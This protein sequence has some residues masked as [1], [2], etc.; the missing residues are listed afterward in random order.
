MNVIPSYA[1]LPL[2]PFLLPSSKALGCS[3]ELLPRPSVPSDLDKT[4]YA[5]GVARA[6]SLRIPLSPRLQVQ[7]DTTQHFQR[8]PR[9]VENDRS[10]CVRN[11]T[12][13]S[14]VIYP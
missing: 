3:A 8:Q 1:R 5:L 6:P 13:K 9:T 14:L 4:T 12:G 2:L 11:L 7:S 10:N